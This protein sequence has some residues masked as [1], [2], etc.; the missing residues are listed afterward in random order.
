MKHSSRT[1]GVV[2][3]MI[4]TFQHDGSEVRAEV[5]SAAW[6]RWLEQA[7]SFMFRDEAGHFTAYKTHAGNRR[8]GSYWR[9]TRRS[10]GRLASYYL[11]PS[12]RLTP[13][14]LR[15]AAHALSAS[16]FADPLER[17]GA[18]LPEVSLIHGQPG[19]VSGDISLLAT[20]LH[21]PPPA[22]MLVARPHLTQYLNE[23][24]QKKLTL[25]CA[26]AGFGK[27]SLLAEWCAW[28][29]RHSEHPA[30]LAWV[31][32]EA[33]E[34]DPEQFWRYVLVA[35][36]RLSSHIGEEA[37][38][39][40]QS[41]EPPSMEVILTSL[42]NSLAAATEQVVLVLDDYHVIEAAPIHQALTYLVDHLPPQMHLILATRSNPPL[43]LARWR[44]RGQLNELRSDEL[45]FRLEETGAFLRKTTGRSL[46][47]EAV[48][49]LSQRTEGWIAGLQLAAL[50]LK[51]RADPADFIRAFA[52]SHRYVLDYLSEEVLRRQPEAVQTFLLETSILERLC[53]PLC[54]AVTGEPG[55]QEMLEYLEQA[56]LFLVPLDDERTWYRYH[57]LFSEVLRHR[58]RRSS[59]ET[60]PELHRQAAT[61]YEQQGLLAEA[62][63]HALAAPDYAQAVRLM[64]RAT[65]PMLRQERSTLKQWI[66][67]LPPEHLTCSPRLCLTYAMLLAALADFEAA[68]PYLQQAE[69]ALQDM[70]QDEATTCMLGEV[71]S[72]RATIA[73]N[74]GDLPRAITLCRRALE[75]IPQD[76]VVLRATVLLTLGA[77]YGYNGKLAAAERAWTEALELSQAAGNLYDVMHALYQLAWKHTTSGHLRLAYHTYQRALHLVQSYPEYRRS[78][79]VGLIYMLMGDTLLEWNALADAAQAVSQGIEHAQQN[80]FEKALSVGAIFLARIRQAQGRSEEAAKLMQH[81]EQIVRQN[82][83]TTLAG[84]SIFLYLVRLWIQQGNLDAAREWGEHYRRTLESDGASRGLYALE[85]FTLVWLLLAERRQGR[86]RAGEHPLEEALSLLEQVRSRAQARREMGAVLEALVL[87]ALVLQDQSHLSEAVNILQEA[88]A[89][90]EP[91]GWIRIF[92]DEGPL[93]AELLQHVAACGRASPYITSLLEAFSVPPNQHHDAEHTQ[94]GGPA[95]LVEPLSER[96]VEVLRLLATGESYAELAQTLVV[97]T[98]TVKTHLQHIYGKLGVTNRTQAVA[99]AQELHLLPS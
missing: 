62:V 11:G 24:V 55:S 49:A 98:N 73:C 69:L 76:Q 46:P 13:D 19:R 38:L 43:P 72:L 60:V 93:M 83:T 74:R 5:G 37:S 95:G 25:L 12:A 64:E 71:E 61:W 2:Q 42:I 34:N 48:A 22:P 44:S 17:E 78:P 9:A 23:G 57:H 40:L 79:H 7:T 65:P 20:K 41:P 21:I 86:N 63:H 53:G 99:R 81:Y 91:E 29:T 56:N 14:H 26:P 89:L 30:A 15:Q 75:R 8:G 87:Q 84:G 10:H 18:S 70:P 45:R 88:L 27:T 85:G 35:L 58:L 68:E 67:A 51:G 80:G 59:P 4:L 31:S 96:E 16:A 28:R 33:S 66:E 32:L 94:P 82:S 39:L 52:G 90:A 54:D 77:S 36:H 6:F 50:S 1:T 92:V 47:A 97:S 3:D